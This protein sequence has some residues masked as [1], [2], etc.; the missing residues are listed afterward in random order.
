LRLPSSV[1]PAKVP[2]MWTKDFIGLYS[3]YA[4][5][6]SLP[7]S[8]TLS[9]SLLFTLCL[10]NSFLIAVGLLYGTSG[11]LY[12]F[13]NYVYKGKRD[14]SLIYPF[15]H[16]FI[17]SPFKS[18]DPNLCANSSSIT[19]FAWNFKIFFAILTDIYRPFGL[20]R[21][22]WMLFGW[23]MVLVILMVSTYLITCLLTNHSLLSFITGAYVWRTHNECIHMAFHAFTHARVLDVF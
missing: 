13:C 8:F 18:G 7:H 1:A 14:N 21:K 23:T 15:I 11:V 16:S 12:P 4:G 17:R 5:S 20:R 3:Q 9:S 2:N 19:F 10:L 6:P 22:P